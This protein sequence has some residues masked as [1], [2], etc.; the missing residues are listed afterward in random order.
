MSIYGKSLSYILQSG[1]RK[2][3]I[4]ITFGIAALL[5]VQALMFSVQAQH[6]ICELVAT[7]NQQLGGPLGREI[8]LGNESVASE[9]FSEYKSFFRRLDAKETL[10]FQKVSDS[11]RNFLTSF[12]NKGLTSTNIQQLVSFGGQ[13]VGVI[14]GEIKYFPASQLLV[15]LMI[16]AFSIFG[17]LQY[18]KREASHTLDRLVLNP[19][20]QLS[21]GLDLENKTELTLEVKRISENFE[22]F[23]VRLLNEQRKHLDYEKN[24]SLAELALKV[25]HDIRSP[26][27]LLKLVTA[28]ENSLEAE[29]QKLMSLALDRIGA[30]SSD[31]LSRYRRDSSAINAIQTSATWEA[32]ATVLNEKQAIHSSKEIKFSTEITDDVRKARMP[33][34]SI[35]IGRIISNIVDN[36]IDAVSN[37]GTVNIK[38]TLTEDQKTIKLSVSDNGAGMSEDKLRMLGRA[39]VTSEKPNGT[40]IGFFSAKQALEKVGGRIWIHSKPGRGSQVELQLPV[41]A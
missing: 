41:L 17:L 40:G 13:P 15:F 6:T 25:A 29:N 23:K 30:I 24:K 34:D 3:V 32:I 9:I 39:P 19:L 36:S 4:V 11:D 16:L 35:S 20:T 12:C 18:W 14:S 27:S 5:T 2:L 33:I 21:K 37:R 22:G 31:L 28:N 1:L 7:K 10:A 8:A 26:L 38:A